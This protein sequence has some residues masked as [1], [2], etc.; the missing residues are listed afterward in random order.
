MTLQEMA[1][2]QKKLNA[3][4]ENYSGIIQRIETGTHTVQLRLCVKDGPESTYTLPD[5][6]KFVD[7]F[8]TTYLTELKTRMSRLDTII[9]RMDDNPNNLTAF[10]VNGFEASVLHEKTARFQIDH[11]F[12]DTSSSHEYDQVVSQAK[13]YGIECSQELTYDKYPC[14]FVD[15]GVL[16]GDIRGGNCLYNKIKATKEDFEASIRQICK[17]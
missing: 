5:D 2:A 13:N 8:R 11:I 4:R 7:D 9:K 12:L 14:L 16:H 17:L 3:E 15:E 10:S 6:A 1:E